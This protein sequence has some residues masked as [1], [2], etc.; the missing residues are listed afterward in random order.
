MPAYSHLDPPCRSTVFCYFRG[1]GS[2]NRNTCNS[3]EFYVGISYPG[4]KVFVLMFV[5]CAKSEGVRE[6]RKRSLSLNFDDPCRC[7]DRR[8][9]ITRE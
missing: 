2:R 8:F 9:L 1:G 5:L 3:Q 4:L 6:L 7:A